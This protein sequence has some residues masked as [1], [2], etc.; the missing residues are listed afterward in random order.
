MQNKA[1]FRKVRMNASFFAAKDYE[2]N[3]ACGVQENKPNQTQFS[4][5]KTEG[6][7]SP[8]SSVIWP[9]Y[10]V[11]E[12]QEKDR[13]GQ[14]R[15]DRMNRKDHWWVECFLSHWL[16]HFSACAGVFTTPSSW[17]MYNSWANWPRAGPGTA[18]NRIKSWPLSSGLGRSSRSPRPF[19]L[20]RSLINGARFLRLASCAF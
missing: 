10:P 20:L 4:N 17:A 18:P 9:R 12:R 13:S 15:I 14:L 3:C 7:Y 1:N 2:N 6:R 19:I 5:R 11:R 8:R 16:A